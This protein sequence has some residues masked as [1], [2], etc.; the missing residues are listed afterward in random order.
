MNGSNNEYSINDIEKK[1]TI[2]IRN[3]YYVVP[4][5]LLRLGIC[6]FHYHQQRYYH[7]SSLH[8]PYMS[9]WSFD[10]GSLLYII[11]K[12]KSSLG[13]ETERMRSRSPM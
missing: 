3:E 12:D 13:V 1:D 5:N 9:V 2:A 7:Y 6:T 4:V 8:S 10:G 11:E